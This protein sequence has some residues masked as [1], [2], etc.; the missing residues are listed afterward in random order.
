MKSILSFFIGLFLAGHCLGQIGLM[1]GYKTFNAPKWEEP[2]E[3][4]L[5]ESP[6]PNAGWQVG[7]DYWFRL[8]KRRI[9][10]TPEVSFANFKHSFSEGEMRMRQF[11]FHFNT[12]VYLFDL[13]SDCNCP[14]FSKDGNVLGKGFFLEVS[15]GIT[16]LQNDLDWVTITRYTYPHKS[17]AFGGSIG[18][19]LD[20]GFSDLFT[21]TPLARFYFYPFTNSL[22]D[23]QPEGIE[24]TELKQVFAGLRFRLHFKEMAKARYR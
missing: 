15:P 18:A 21:V 6:Y 1:A 19:G 24:G 5:N 8:K 16:Y 11:G 13:A 9:E 12:A 10:F 17:L 23:L 14:T 22:D 7:M 4:L 2:F 20:I 3:A